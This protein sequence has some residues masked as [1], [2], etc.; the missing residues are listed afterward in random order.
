MPMQKIWPKEPRD[1]QPDQNSFRVFFI[2]KNSLGVPNGRARRAI[3]YLGYASI[4]D[5]L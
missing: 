1:D 2:P 3:C 5:F 4:V